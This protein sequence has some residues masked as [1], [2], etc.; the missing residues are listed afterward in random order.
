MEPDQGGKVLSGT[1]SMAAF[2]DFSLSI[3][4]ENRNQIA[5]GDGGLNGQVGSADG[6]CRRFFK[7]DWL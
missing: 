4:H 3:D 1:W 6:Q 7:E 5:M 2:N